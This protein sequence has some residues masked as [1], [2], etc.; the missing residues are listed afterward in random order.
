MKKIFFIL[1]ALPAAAISAPSVPVQPVSGYGA[2]QVTP[3]TG[4]FDVAQT[5]NWALDTISPG[6]TA[7][8]AASAGI[9]SSFGVAINWNE[10]K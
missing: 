4:T 5:G 7:I 6:E 8:F 3:G 1:L 9:V 10:D 2:F